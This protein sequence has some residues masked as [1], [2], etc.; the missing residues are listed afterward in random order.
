MR[1][2]PSSNYYRRRDEPARFRAPTSA[3]A[4]NRTVDR[5][6]GTANCAV[7]LNHPR[8]PPWPDNRLRRSLRTRPG[9][10]HNYPL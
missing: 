9:K 3:H 8:N 5:R 2:S 1:V 4:N 6:T 10:G 7:A